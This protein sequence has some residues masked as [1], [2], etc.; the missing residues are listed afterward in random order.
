MAK[1]RSK[2]QSTGTWECPEGCPVTAKPCPHLEKLLPSAE[3]GKDGR[4]L[5]YSDNIDALSTFFYDYLPSTTDA[6]VRNFVTKLQKY[7]L[8][9]Y[10]VEILV[11]RFVN[12]KTIKEITDESGYT[13][14]G[15]AFYIIKKAIEK[16]KT[17][18]FGKDKVRKGD[19]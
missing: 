6:E 7:G 11:E 19:S 9:D 14:P 3:A 12:N 4:K 10:E 18:G 5:V 13:S 17:R 15:A 16:L 8:Q 2:Q 1:K